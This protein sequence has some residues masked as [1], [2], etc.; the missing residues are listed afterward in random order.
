MPDCQQLLTNYENV[1]LGAEPLKWKMPSAVFVHSG[2][3][4]HVPPAER[5]RGPAFRQTCP[6]CNTRKASA[7]TRACSMPPARWPRSRMPT[8]STRGNIAT[9]LIALY[10]ALGG[11]WEVRLGNDFVPEP[12]CAR[13]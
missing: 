3:E 5:R 8:P 6:C 9:S 2:V 12:R 11:G 10:K 1:V 13:Q 7:S 4:A